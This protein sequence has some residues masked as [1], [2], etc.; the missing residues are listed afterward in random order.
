VSSR[1]P[2]ILALG[3]HEIDELLDLES[4]IESQRAAFIGL[5]RGTAQL[6]PRV[7][8]ASPDEGS[9]A[10]CYTARLSAETGPVCK[11]GSVNPAN[12]VAGLPSVSALVLVLDPRTGQP[13]AILDGEAITTART[14]AASVVA[15]QALARPGSQIV[16]VLG[17]GTQGKAHARALARSLPVAEVRMWSPLPDERERVAAELA[18]ELNAKVLA[19]NTAFDAAGGASIVVT[20]TTS[21]EPVLQADW[22]EPGTTVLGVGS[23]APDR[24]EVG[25]D[26]IRRANA[27][28]VD[29]LDTALAQAGPIVHAVSSG[30]LMPQRIVSL[31]EVLTGSRPGRTSDS[32]V[33]FYNS[34]GL[35][36]QDAAAAWLVLDRA[37]GRGLGTQIQL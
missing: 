10:F 30:A 23:F 12:Q 36:I 17:C 26:L 32:D 11:F 31:G 16:S 22:I 8:L 4:V 3:R 24:R 14:P 5:A 19:A 34:V 27:I 7:L 1:P 6:A 37:A 20:A 35:G 33:I 29:H 2:S 18:S 9:V 28:V 21:S 25:D 13:R 15:A